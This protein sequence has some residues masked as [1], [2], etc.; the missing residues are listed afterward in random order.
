MPP[1]RNLLSLWRSLPC[2]ICTCATAIPADDFHTRVSEQPLFE[3][4]GFSIR[5]QVERNPSFE[6]DE[7]RSIAPSPAETKVI[8]AQHPRR[9][10]LALFLCAHEPQERVRTGL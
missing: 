4:L 9:W 7:D 2:T 10:H 6:V 3:R 5:K 8:H 1:V